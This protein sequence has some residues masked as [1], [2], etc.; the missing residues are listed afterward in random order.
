[1][2][3]PMSSESRSTPSVTEIIGP[4]ICGPSSSHTAGPCR[5]GNAVFEICG[6][7]PPTFVEFTLFNSFAGTGFL[8]GTQVAL[9]AGVLGVDPGDE[10]L[11]DAPAV[12]VENGVNFRFVEVLDAPGMHPNAVSI[13][14]SFELGGRSF[15]SVL[16]GESLGGGFINVLVIEPPREVTQE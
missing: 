3:D 1:M 15:N 5:I 7:S 4:I 2:S 6:G 14:F 9:L 8:H 11:W 10:R 13:R 16:L 12:A